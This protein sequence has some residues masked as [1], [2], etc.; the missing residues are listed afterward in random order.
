MLFQAA[1]DFRTFVTSLQDI[2]AFDVFFPFLLVFAI[3]FAA[4]E[5]THVLGSKSNIN[6]V[7]ALVVGILLVVQTSIVQT[8]NTFLPSVSLILV[9]AVMILLVLS[10]V[11]GKTF[12][13]LKGLSLGAAVILSLIAIGVALNPD[14]SNFL[15]TYDRERL[16]YWALGILA[17][18]GGIWLVTGG[19][20]GATNT[21]ATPISTRAANFFND[22]IRDPPPRP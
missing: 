22:L 13:G 1:F 16:L 5:K 14:W 11:S 18:I 10:V 20:R 3:V 2:G 7:V 17:F 15:S 4:L 19:S 8:I 21:P 6:I 12:G 9:V